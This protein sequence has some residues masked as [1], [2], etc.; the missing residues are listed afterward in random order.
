MAPGD[1][2]CPQLSSRDRLGGAWQDRGFRLDHNTS[3]EP[4]DCEQF[5]FLSAKSTGTRTA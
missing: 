1:I 5:D 3:P 2:M 4:D